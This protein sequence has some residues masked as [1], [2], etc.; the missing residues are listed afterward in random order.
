MNLLT[1]ESYLNPALQI[2]DL[3]I[4]ITT[5]MCTPK[6]NFAFQYWDIIKRDF[7]RNHNGEVMGCGLKV[8]PNE[9]VEEIHTTLFP[10][11]AEEAVSFEESYE[12]HIERMR[13][14]YSVLMSEEE[15]DMHFPQKFT[16]L[17][18]R[19]CRV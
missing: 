15:L 14:F 1:T 9:I 17:K 7:H 8:F 11:E 13:H 18:S 6:R 4:G 16:S 10:E 5:R 3:V 2:A 12:E 19:P